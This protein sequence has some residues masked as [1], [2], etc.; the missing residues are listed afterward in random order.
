MGRRRSNGSVETIASTPSDFVEAAVRGRIRDMES[1]AST[2]PYFV[3]AA[4]RRNIG[5]LE[6]LASTPPGFVE[7]VFSEK[8]WDC[9]RVSSSH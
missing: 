6:S 5:G 9:I 8:E 2:P 1:L 4:I 7:A 3:E